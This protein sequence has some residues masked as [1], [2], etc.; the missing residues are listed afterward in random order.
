M[1]HCSSLPPMQSLEEALWRDASA[2][3]PTEID[4]LDELE[5]AEVEASWQAT[6]TEGSS[7]LA[8]PCCGCAALFGAP[9]DRVSCQECHLCLRL[10]SLEALRELLAGALQVN[11]HGRYL[12]SMFR[13]M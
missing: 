6:A 10:P 3:E 2:R 9:G 5:A 4:Y 1:A 12:Y 8:C 7:T 13:L 11:V